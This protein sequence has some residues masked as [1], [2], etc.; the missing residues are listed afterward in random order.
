MAERVLEVSELSVR[1]HGATVVDRVSFRLEAETDTALVGPNGAGKSSLV[2]A[3]LGIVPHAGG[4]VRLLG[5]DP[6]ANCRHRY[7]N[8]WPTCPRP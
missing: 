8:R 3:I 5:Q 6:M 1:R 4:E 2:Q 7:V